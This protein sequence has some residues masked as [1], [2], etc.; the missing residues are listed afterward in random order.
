VAVFW[1]ATLPLMVWYARRQVNRW[2]ALGEGLG[3]RPLGEAGSLASMTDYRTLRGD[4]GQREAQVRTYTT[5]S[6]KS[7][8]HWTAFALALPRA[9]PGFRLRITPE[10]LG[11]KLAKLAGGQ[12]VHVGDA[13][14]DAAFRIEGSDEARVC[15]ALD[16]AVRMELP[17]LKP[18][19]RVEVGIALRDDQGVLLP[20]A[21]E[22]VARAVQ[23]LRTATRGHLTPEEQAA[24]DASLPRAGASAVLVLT[25]KGFHPDPDVARVAF[26]TLG[27]LADAV[28]RAAPAPD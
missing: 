2:R 21:P 8:V 18:L 19:A 25:R 7:K 3:F 1:L 27:R 6:G 15:A 11:A 14:F 26:A 10:G 20:D 23:A 28:E 5:G 13:D 24:V 12:D 22:R 4:I 16:A 9:D 17:T